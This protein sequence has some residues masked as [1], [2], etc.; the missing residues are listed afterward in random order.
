MILQTNNFTQ[1][2]YLV[3][4]NKLDFGGPFKVV[5]HQRW[6]VPTPKSE[7]SL[8]PIRFQTYRRNLK[9]IYILSR[10]TMGLLIVYG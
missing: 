9:T 1:T 5:P 4:P 3:V 6:V 7:S 8:K 10:P 2:L